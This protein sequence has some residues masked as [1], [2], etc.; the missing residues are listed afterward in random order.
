[1]REENVQ[2]QKNL[3]KIHDMNQRRVSNKQIQYIYLY[4]ELVIY[5]FLRF[6]Y[7]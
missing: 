2:K 5:F 7:L 4:L 1:M 6:I 3:E